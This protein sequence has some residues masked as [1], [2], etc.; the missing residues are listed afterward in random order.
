ML[1]E[2][3]LNDGTFEEEAFLLDVKAGHLDHRLQCPATQVSIHES[4]QVT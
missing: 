4:L 3:I 1:K 2:K